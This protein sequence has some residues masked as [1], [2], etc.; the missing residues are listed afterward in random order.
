VTSTEERLIG[1]Q[2]RQ[3]QYAAL[4]HDLQDPRKTVAFGDRLIREYLQRES[5]EIKLELYEIDKEL[6]N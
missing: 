2:A 5:E 4:I 6:H 1:V 3:E